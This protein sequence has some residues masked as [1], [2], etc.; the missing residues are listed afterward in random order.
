M[1]NEIKGSQRVYRRV[2]GERSMGGIEEE[3]DKDFYGPIERERQQREG[4]GE[5]QIIG[6]ERKKVKKKK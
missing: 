6:R 1:E 5:K 4:K 2:D 3:K